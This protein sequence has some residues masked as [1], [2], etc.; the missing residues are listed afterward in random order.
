MNVWKH[1]RNWVW[2][3]ED[4]RLLPLGM[5]QRIITKSEKFDDDTLARIEAKYEAKY[6]CETCLKTKDGQWINSATA[7]FY[8]PDATKIPEGG[9]HW[10]GLFFR[11]DPMAG[12]DGPRRL[13]ICNAITAVEQDITGIVAENGDIIYSR[14]R[15]D[16]HWSE[17]KTVM[18]DGGRN[19]DRHNMGGPLVTLRIMEDRLIVVRLGGAECVP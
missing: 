5:H 14:Y 18:I 16:Y 12:P 7:I 6:V 15:H 10:F 2:P 19:Y 9:S 11:V 4:P 1:F 8:Q 17:D 13:M 3:K